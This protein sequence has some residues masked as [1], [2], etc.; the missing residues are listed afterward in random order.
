MYSGQQIVSIRAYRASPSGSYA[1]L[2]FLGNMFLSHW[3]PCNRIT[4]D[5][6]AGGSWQASVN[7]QLKSVGARPAGEVFRHSIKGIRFIFYLIGSDPFTATRNDVA[8][9][10]QSKLCTIEHQ[11]VFNLKSLRALS[12]VSTFPLECV[13]ADSYPIRFAPSRPRIE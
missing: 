9:V 5:Q 3:R 7:E 1:A 6:E 10:V 13:I 4:R 11:Q 8:W 2:G 12:A